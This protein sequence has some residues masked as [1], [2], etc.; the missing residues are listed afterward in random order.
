MQNDKA[1][2]NKWTTK[3]C[4]INTRVG[5][6]GTEKIVGSQPSRFAIEWPERFGVL[7]N[8]PIE[9]IPTPNKHAICLRRR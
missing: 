2:N 1:D 5:T 4:N 3:A 8:H 7:V 9:P 6:D